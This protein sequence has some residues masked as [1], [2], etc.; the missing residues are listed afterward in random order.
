MEI[1]FIVI[2]LNLWYIGHTLNKILE[3][4]KNKKL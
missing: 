4:I 1:T 3:Q 2:A